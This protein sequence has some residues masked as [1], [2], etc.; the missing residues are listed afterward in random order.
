MTAYYKLSTA[1]GLN[2]GT[3]CAN[4]AEE[5]FEMMAREAKYDSLADMM[6]R[7][8]VMRSEIAE[9]G[10]LVSEE[11]ESPTATRVTHDGCSATA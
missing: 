8:G 11:V 3:Y 7:N 2:L 10:P 1:S 4:S 5:A 6:E 9:V